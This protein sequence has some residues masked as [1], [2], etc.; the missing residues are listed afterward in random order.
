MP[1]LPQALLERRLRNEEEEL[2]GKGYSFESTPIWNDVSIASVIGQETVPVARRYDVRLKASGLTRQGIADDP[3]KIS[4]HQAQVFILISYPYPTDK[5]QLG[6][7]FRVVWLSSIFHPN[8]AKGVSTGGTGIVCWQLLKDW[9]NLD[10]L[11]GIVKGLELLIE[12]PNPKSALNLE[13]CKAAAKWY[14]SHKSG[15]QTLI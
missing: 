11:F 5:S 7:P 13:E 3:T 8:I 4:E 14:D 12:H 6:A 2:R 9:T 10:T 1:R 15:S